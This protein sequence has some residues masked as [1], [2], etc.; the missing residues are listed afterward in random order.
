VPAVRQL[1]PHHEPVVDPAIAYADPRRA[2]VG[3]RPWVLLNMIASID[4][5]TAVQGRSGGLGG[6]A[7]K[8]T[9][10]AI[11]S[12]ADLI[13]VAAGT[14]R[15]ERYRAPTLSDHLVDQRRRRGQADLPR[16][17]VISL[18]LDLGDWLPLFAP[19]APKPI[20]VTS[21]DAPAE[22][23]E[24]VAETAELVACGLGGV[25]VVE[26]LATLR[27]RY[28]ADVVLAEGG[29]SLNGALADAGVID[30]VCLT[31]A[32]HLVGG[33]SRRML[34]GAGPLLNTFGLA[35]LLEQDGYLFARYVYRPDG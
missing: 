8:A 20:V 15:A 30:E 10:M 7:D 16:L 12:V 31:V 28:G 17:A 13:L 24:A 35:H 27:S 26:A 3:E 34:H 21:S 22:R 19:D 33:D 9:F 5:G 25:D 18:S 23:L 2:P 11:R 29:P 4:G 32:P 14:A 6:A 1:L